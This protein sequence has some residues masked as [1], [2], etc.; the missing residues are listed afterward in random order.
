MNKSLKRILPI[1]ILLMIL[2]SIVW[3]LFIYDRDFTRDLLMSQA[4]FFESRGEHAVSSFLY[5][6]AYRQSDD[7]AS[8]AIALAEQ[9]KSVSYTHLTLPTMAVV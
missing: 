5:D 7:N 8:V 3:Y 4:R 2:A 9:F 1:L 6:L